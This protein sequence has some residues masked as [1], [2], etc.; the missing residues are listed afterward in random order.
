MVC[1]HAV[2]MSWLKFVKPCIGSA[3]I[4]CSGKVQ[5]E[6]NIQGYNGAR[7]CSNECW[8][9]VSDLITR[10]LLFR[11]IPWFVEPSTFIVRNLNQT[12][13]APYFPL[14]RS[15]IRRTC[16]GCFKNWYLIKHK[17][18]FTT[19]LHKHTKLIVMSRQFP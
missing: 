13:D 7:G 8:I 2:N 19:E 17:Q 12:S 3:A 11:I 5:R 10:Q 16:T 14:F 18:R 15:K 9:L 1:H 6:P 4:S